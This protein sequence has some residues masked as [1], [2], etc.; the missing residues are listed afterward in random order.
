MQSTMVP[1]TAV[2]PAA[3]TGLGILVNSLKQEVQILATITA[4][5]RS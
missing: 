5:T 3:G 1:L 2:T 4:K